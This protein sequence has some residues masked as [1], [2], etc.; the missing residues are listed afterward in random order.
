M[1]EEDV[2]VEPEIDEVVVDDD[3]V[4]D[5]LDVDPELDVLVDDEVAD[6]ELVAVEGAVVSTKPSGRKSR[7]KAKVEE[8]EDE[9]DVVDLDEEHH[10]DDVEASLDVLLKER[11]TS[12]AIDADEE[13]LDDEDDV[14]VDDRADGSTRVVPRRS[15]EFLCQK[16][17]LVLPMNQLAD[18]KKQ[19]CRD[20][21]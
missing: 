16:C 18:K 5:D 3:V 15:N 14:E 2:E 13:E 21:A 20:C 8:A 1:T 9:D 12:G 4:D 10:P 19:L 11:T 17:F 6:E 7:A